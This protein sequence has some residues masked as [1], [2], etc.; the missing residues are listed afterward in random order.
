LIK[1][2]SSI[3]LTKPVSPDKPAP[4]PLSGP[5][6]SGF[7]NLRRRRL[8]WIPLFPKVIGFQKGLTRTLSVWSNT[9]L[10]DP[11]LFYVFSIE[12]GRETGRRCVGDD[13][14]HALSTAY[15]LKDGQQTV[16]RISG[17]GTE[18]LAD[19][20]DRLYRTALKNGSHK[21]Q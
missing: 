12:A 9:M 11:N 2:D 4:S 18:I 15:G 20:I 7:I 14:Q 13:V 5:L 19:E 1:S 17:P 21:P 8:G 6:S 10:Y 16:T 3:R